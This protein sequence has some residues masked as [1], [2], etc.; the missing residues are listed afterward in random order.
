MRVLLYILIIIEYISFYYVFFGKRQF[1]KGKWSKWICLGIDLF[2]IVFLLNVNQMGLVLVLALIGAIINVSA[3]FDITFMENLK[4]FLLCYPML[5]I[6]ESI[7]QYG[8]NYY[9]ELNN[10]SITIIYTIIIIGITWIYY[11]LA[12]RKIEKSSFVLPT[13]ISLLLSAVLFIIVAMITYFTYAL[14]EI[15]HTANGKLGLGLVT[16]GGGIIF[17][18]VLLMI[19]YFNSQQRFQLENKMLEKYNE[20]QREYFE[21][22]LEKEQKTKQFRHD[23][24]AELVEI[25]NLND[26]K[27]YNKLDEF[28]EDMLNEISSISNSDYDVGNEIINTILNYYL[29]PI[30]SACKITVKGYIPD[31]LSITRRDLCII[32]SNLIKNAVEA[33]E[34]VESSHRYI[35]VVIKSGK[36][37][38]DIKINNSCNKADGIFV[39]GK[40]TTSKKDKNNHGFGM[41]NIENV[42]KKYDGD[43]TYGKENNDFGAE[44]RV[45]NNRSS[46]K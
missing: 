15:L 35:T 16:V 32:V 7:I 42:V 46:K 30:K 19:Y 44:V 39:D 12:R 40:I 2:S 43:Y 4:L 41:K 26:S 29:S 18:L 11:A 3:L 33:V 10:R 14:T 24:I 1:G 13:A 8:L 17:I 37:F 22:L 21:Q 25:K 36:I 23:I 34:T 28:L 9:L 27:E 20:Q 5:T 31:E 38:L 45:K 6:L